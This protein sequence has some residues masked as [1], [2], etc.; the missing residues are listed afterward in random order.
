MPTTIRAT[1]RDGID[2]TRAVTTY[3]P[4]I[5]SAIPDLACK[6]CS[7]NAKRTRDPA[8]EPKSTTTQDEKD[9]QSRRYK[10][11]N[12]G[13]VSEHIQNGR[14]CNFVISANAQNRT[15]KDSAHTG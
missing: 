11:T 3:K 8:N 7:D 10:A 9:F 13:T 12:E 6:R 15:A 2:V 14:T 1:S 4:R 5:G